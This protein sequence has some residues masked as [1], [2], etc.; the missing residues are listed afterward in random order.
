MATRKW[1]LG[2]SAAGV[3]VGCTTINDQIGD[4]LFIPNPNSDRR[5]ESVDLELAYST[6]PYCKWPRDMYAPAA[7]ECEFELPPRDQVKD[8]LAAMSGVPAFDAAK[9]AKTILKQALASE[10]KRYSATIA[11][12]ASSGQFYHYYFPTAP[13]AAGPAY[14]DG[15]M[16]FGAYR[17]ETDIKLAGFLLTRRLAPQG[18]AREVGPIAMRICAI[19]LPSQT[20]DFVSVV[21]VSY[22]YRYSKAKLIGFN[23]LSPFGVD[24]LNPWEAVT[25][26]FSG[27]GYRL[28]PA[29]RDVDASMQI[30]F[31]HMFFD[32]GAVKLEPTNTETYKLPKVAI[33][34][35]LVTRYFPNY[36]KFKEEIL[37]NSSKTRKPAFDADLPCDDTASLEAISNL[38]DRIM[39]NVPLDNFAR[40]QLE[41]SGNPF[42]SPRR[43]FNSSTR[44][45][46]GNANFTLN[47]LVTETDDFGARIVE[48]NKTLEAEGEKPES[49][50]SKFLENVQKPFNP[51]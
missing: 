33:T 49:D 6:N 4:I 43:A 5:T 45:P 48:I 38:R 2:A 27:K 46:R 14:R 1:I 3:L 39:T 20:D 19:V 26:S 7:G 32:K 47:V 22:A 42:Q 40:M 31:E 28:P 24:V 13:S 30:G 15:S 9:I 21:P 34:G 50:L 37:E 36:L 17:N 10:A 12:S 16:G 35:K 23:L 51:N 11:A 18:K 8:A 44:W 25:N 29:D 41:A